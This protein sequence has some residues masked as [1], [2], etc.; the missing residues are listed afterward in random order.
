MGDFLHL[1]YKTIFVLWPSF[2]HSSPFHD[3]NESF[4]ETSS[5]LKGWTVTCISSLVNKVFHPSFGSIFFTTES[6]CSIIHLNPSLLESQCLI[7]L[8]KF[9]FLFFCL[10]LISVSGFFIFSL[11]SS[12]SSSSSSSHVLVFNHTA[13]PCFVFYLYVSSFILTLL[14]HHLSVFH[15]GYLDAIIHL[16]SIVPSFTCISFFSFFYYLITLIT[17]FSMLPF[18]DSVITFICI[19]V[20]YHSLRGPG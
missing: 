14:F 20:L 17:F 9:T 18:H 1:L 12:S 5:V 13:R 6:R 7:I 4:I 16:Y 11:S 15:F 8:M 3:L 2:C 10:D 19:S